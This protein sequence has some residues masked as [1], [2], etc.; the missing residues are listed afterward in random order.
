MLD[1]LSAARIA[2]HY[3]K[4]GKETEWVEFKHNNAD[5]DEIGARLSA[6]SNMAAIKGKRF[7][8]ILWGIEDESCDVVGTNLSFA[9]WKKG[10]E[11]VQAYWKN[12]LSPTVTLSVCD[13]SI[14]GKRILV[15][16]ISKAE[17]SP[18]TFKKTAYCRV[19]SYTKKLS[20][21]PSIEKELWSALSRSSAE[22]MIVRD[23]LSGEEVLSLLDASQYF[24]VLNMPT[25]ASNS[26]MLRAFV[27]EG[28]IVEDSGAFGVTVL[29]A[30]LF[31]KSLLA[32]PSLS[33]KTI[34]LLRYATSS[35]F[36]TMGKREFSSGYALC[37]EEVIAT[38]LPFLALPD[39]F[40]N[41]IRIDQYR[42]PALAVREAVANALIHQDLSEGYGPLIELFPERVEFSNSGALLVPKDRLIDTVPTPR[43]PKLAA[44]LRRANIGDS[45]G[46]GYDKMTYAMEQRHLPSP[47]VDD[48]VTGVRVSLSFEKGYAEMS[49]EER[50]QA[51]YDHAVLRYLEG[52]ALTNPS[53]RERFGLGEDAKFQISRLIRSL[54]EEGKLKAI[55]GK[56]KNQSSYLPYWA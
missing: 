56:N 34:R 22:E 14:D 24:R 52:K 28:F 41:G 48:A 16:E 19:D 38:V 40:A 35:R 33:S 32:F 11:N 51:T 18:T 36:S 49:S 30:I 3:I 9:S 8:Y 12:L 50:K 29:G 54:L 21:Y 55:E 17:Y 31:A 43:N 26:E 15:A 23:N 44:F 39:G 42:L 2:L 5:P 1:E 37:Y 6:V 53:L 25:P 47:K 13:T 10:N 7:G 20:D 45:S 46:S 4:K 27:S